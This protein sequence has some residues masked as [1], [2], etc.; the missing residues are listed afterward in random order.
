MTFV[1]AMSSNEQVK[2]A[3]WVKMNSSVTK[4]ADDLN[5]SRPTVYKYM[6]AYDRGD[7]EQIPDEVIAYFDQKVSSSDSITTLQV[8]LKLKE[9]IIHL[10]YR[11]DEL[12][13]RLKGLME[14]SSN[15][16][17]HLI[18]IKQSNPDSMEALMLERELIEKKKEIQSC[19]VEYERI[20]DTISKLSMEL[21]SYEQTKVL[22][23]VSKKLYKIQ[24]KCY[25]EDK[26]CMI[27]YNGEHWD[28]VEY[29]LYL[30]AK[31]DSDYVFLKTYVDKESWNYFII[32][33]VL[34]SAPLYYEICRCSYDGSLDFDGTPIMTPD[35]EETTGMCELKQRK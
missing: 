8:K 31:L 23:S 18:E 21:A 30:Y 4:V 27:I 1:N 14:S 20:Q 17:R 29:R 15:I 16:E 2:I 7:K 13:S 10:N 11:A 34:F 24:S 25:F 6:E 26:K 9:E 32:D 3:D 22:P 35:K 33:D 19:S 12:S 28:D 5:L